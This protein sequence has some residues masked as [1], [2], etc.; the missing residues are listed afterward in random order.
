MVCNMGK[1]RLELEIP[2][3]SQSIISVTVHSPAYTK[4]GNFSED[5][6]ATCCGYKGPDQLMS[7]PL[8]YTWMRYVPNLQTSYN[9]LTH[10]AKSL[11]RVGARARSVLCLRALG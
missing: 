4:G 1:P 9:A 11:R 5:R 3:R 2:Q 6:P 10:G 8:L 7:R